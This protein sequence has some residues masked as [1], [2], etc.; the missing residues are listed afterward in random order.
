MKKLLNLAYKFKTNFEMKLRYMDLKIQ[1]A[2]NQTQ[3]MKT[4]KIKKLLNKQ[5]SKKMPESKSD[6]LIERF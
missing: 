5:M 3:I 6:N 2:Q 1:I 4:T